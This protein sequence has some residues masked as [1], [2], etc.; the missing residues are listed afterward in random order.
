MCYFYNMHLDE[1]E[2]EAGEMA[3]WLVPS[4]AEDLGLGPLTNVVTHHNLSLQFH[5]GLHL[6]FASADIRHP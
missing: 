2:E 1:E 3:Q 6:L 5:A 4:L